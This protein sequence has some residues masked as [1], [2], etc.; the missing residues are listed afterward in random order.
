M[1]KMGGGM[2]GPPKRGRGRPSLSGET[3]ERY[4]VTIPPSIEARVRKFGGGS[5]SAGIIKLAT[6]IH[7]GHPNKP[8]VTPPLLTTTDLARKQKAGQKR[9][10]H[11]Q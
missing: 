5:L 7:D 9:R 2:S 6:L 4:Q 11:N 3:G 10:A 8:V 1:A